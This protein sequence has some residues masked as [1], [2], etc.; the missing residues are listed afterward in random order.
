M[1]T[2]P[3]QGVVLL[4][5]KLFKWFEHFLQKQPHIL[6]YTIFSQR[7]GVQEVQDNSQSAE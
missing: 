2:S 4:N 5:M 6:S 3:G 7:Q 1:F